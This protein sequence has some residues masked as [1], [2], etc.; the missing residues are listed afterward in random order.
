MTSLAT[1]R[2]DFNREKR[3]GRPL[4]SP[5]QGSGKPVPYRR[6]TTY[7]GVLEDLYNLQRWERRMVALGLA[8]R[9][10]LLLAVAAHREDKQ[11]LN[12]ICDQAKEAAKASSG[13][14][15]GTALH[16]LT[17]IVDEGGDL[18]PLPPG[19]AASLEMFRRATEPL[20][21]VAIEQ[22]L[23]LD[24][25][26][27]AGTADRIYEY[28]GERFIG[29]TKSGNIELGIL[30]I[31]M[32]LAVYARS[33]TYDV[34]T[35]ERGRHECSLTRGLVMH[36][37]ATDDPRE[38]KVDLIWVDLIAGWEAVMVARQ[39]WEQRALKY[40]DLTAPFTDAAPFRRTV[41]EVD[42]TRTL[43]QILAGPSPQSLETL[44]RACTSADA[45]RA[46]W[47][48][49]ASQWTDE[50]TALAKDHIAGLEA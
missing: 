35:G 28:N 11:Q 27:V 21:V 15:I 19:P 5:P 42:D 4:I 22:K 23:V 29:D 50:L 3:Y 38:A 6:A 40:A 32:Q 31:C 41:A 43:K 25:H 13:A 46:L 26:Q 24:T 33:Y 39:V 8:E 37:P 48:E 49:H 16:A 34:R 17:D 1:V 30:K 20:R 47:T 9:P 10:D 7:V 14:T 36:M 44:I 18:P 12:E 45:V 2:P